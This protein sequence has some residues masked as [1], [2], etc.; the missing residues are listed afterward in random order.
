MGPSKKM[1]MK[2]Q[3]FHWNDDSS[4]DDFSFKKRSKSVNVAH[5]RPIIKGS[6][7]CD[8]QKMTD[9]EANLLMKVTKGDS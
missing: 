7:T 9:D 6:D 8:Y 5:A 3:V 4:D 2:T 1:K